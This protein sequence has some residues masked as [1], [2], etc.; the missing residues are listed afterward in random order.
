MSQEG[1][2]NIASSD[3]SLLKG[4]MWFEHMRA[5]EHSIW[6]ACLLSHPSFLVRCSY[7]QNTQGKVKAIYTLRKKPDWQQLVEDTKL[8]VASFITKSENLN[9]S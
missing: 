4:T 6:L 8:T 5:K 1:I 7:K 9:G 3:T 2:L